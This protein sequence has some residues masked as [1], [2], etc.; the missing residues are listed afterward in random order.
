MSPRTRETLVVDRTETGDRSEDNDDCQCEVERFTVATISQPDVVF[1]SNTGFTDVIRNVWFVAYFRQ[2][3]C[4]HCCQFRQ[5]VRGYAELNGVPLLPPV[6]NLNILTWEEDQDAAGG[7]YGHRTQPGEPGDRYVPRQSDGCIYLGMD[8]PGFYNLRPGDDYFIYFEFAD[9]I[10]DTCNDNE[11]VAGPEF[12][13]M[14]ASG[15][16]P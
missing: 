3:G 10:I 14:I 1:H 16:V 8:A 13:D 11:V 15:V 6:P 5:Y 9:F 12:W 7:M 4:C 2:N